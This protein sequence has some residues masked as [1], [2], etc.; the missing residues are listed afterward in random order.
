MSQTIGFDGIIIL[1][2]LVNFFFITWRVRILSKNTEKTL[3]KVVYRPLRELIV[4]LSPGNE[5]Q[6]DTHIINAI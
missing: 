4:S 1:V 6:F 2:A 3:K 5:R